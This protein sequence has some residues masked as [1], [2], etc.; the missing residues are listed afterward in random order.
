MSNK[1][2]MN[3]TANRYGTITPSIQVRTKENIDGK[4]IIHDNIMPYGLRWCNVPY[5][6]EGIKLGKLVFLSQKQKKFSKKEV[7]QMEK[8]I[9]LLEKEKAKKEKIGMEMI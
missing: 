7:E 9:T 5:L 3:E 8:R 6:P 1:Q 2:N 4:M